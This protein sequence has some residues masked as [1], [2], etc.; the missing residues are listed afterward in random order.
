MMSTPIQRPQFTS[1]GIRQNVPLTKLTT[2]LIQNIYSYSV[3]TSLT[4]TCKELYHICNQPGSF[5]VIGSLYQH[6]SNPIFQQML[7]VSPNQSTHTTFQPLDALLQ[8]PDAIVAARTETTLPTP[9]NKFLYQQTAD[10]IIDQSLVKVWKKLTDQYPAL[11]LMENATLIREALQLPAIQETLSQITTL[12]LNSTQPEALRAWDTLRTLPGCPLNDISAAV[13][14]EEFTVGGGHFA[15]DFYDKTMGIRY[16]PQELAVHLT[17]LTRL[18]HGQ[19][20]IIPTASP[21]LT[22]VGWAHNREGTTRENLEQRAGQ[23]KEGLSTLLTAIH[24]TM[25]TVGPERDCSRANLKGAIVQAKTLFNELKT[26]AMLFSVPF[27]FKEHSELL[28]T[29]NTAYPCL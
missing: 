3:N 16:F 22:T 23:F 13:L 6:S 28:D 2:P 17:S 26:A 20:L 29:I 12:N 27:D 25:N 11:P 24:K 19:G 15:V 14:A 10:E 7:K 8:S 5:R 18:S 21:S 4:A 9:F 1:P